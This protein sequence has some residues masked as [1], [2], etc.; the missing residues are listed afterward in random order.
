MKHRHFTQAARRLTALTLAL[1]LA[2][3]S[4]Y[5]AA[6]STQLR[7][8]RVLADCLTYSNTFTS[9]SASGRV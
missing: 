8:S 3:P 2:L 7:T 1:L 5:A 4:A 9:H 6:G